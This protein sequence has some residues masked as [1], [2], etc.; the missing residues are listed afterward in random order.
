MA[1]KVMMYY[2]LIINDGGYIA[3]FDQGSE[4]E[5]D[6]YGQMADYPD[7]CSGWYKCINHELVVDEE[8]KAE[9][10]KR[11]E[12]REAEP[13]RMD[14]I[15]AQTFYTAMMTDTLVEE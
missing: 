4:D 5:Y 9:I 13:S 12:E 8:R 2:Q 11:R 3:G 6:F 14:I 15:E 7:V 10:I 1:E